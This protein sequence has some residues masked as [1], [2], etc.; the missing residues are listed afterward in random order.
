[1][2]LLELFYSMNRSAQYMS[3]PEIIAKMVEEAPNVT[4]AEIYEIL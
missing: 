3:H 1:M 2:V 4:G